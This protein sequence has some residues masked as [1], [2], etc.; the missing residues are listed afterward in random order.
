VTSIE[1]VA[2]D[3]PAATRSRA[4]EIIRSLERAEEGSGYRVARLLEAVDRADAVNQVGAGVR[5]DAGDRADA[6]E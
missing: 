5:I 1:L 6:G 3:R 4:E 2:E